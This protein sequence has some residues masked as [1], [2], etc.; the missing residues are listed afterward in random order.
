M[1]DHKIPMEELLKKLGSKLDTGMT[2]EMAI[3]RNLEEGDN[4]LP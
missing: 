4:K 2:T 3:K 1:V